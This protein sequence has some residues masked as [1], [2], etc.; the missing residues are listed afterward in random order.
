VVLNGDDLNSKNGNFVEGERDRPP[1]Q[2]L[3]PDFNMDAKMNYYTSSQN[4]IQAPDNERLTE[5]NKDTRVMKAKEVYGDSTMEKYGGYSEKKD[6]TIV[7]SNSD[8]RDTG[9]KQD[10]NTYAKTADLN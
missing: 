2:N 1:K 4:W 3:N 7:A 9:F 5:Q 8:W 6:K 10:T